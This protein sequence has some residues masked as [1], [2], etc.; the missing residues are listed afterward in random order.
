MSEKLKNDIL[1]IKEIGEKIAELS[2][3]NIINP[4][5]IRTLMKVLEYGDVNNS[6]SKYLKLKKLVYLTEKL[7]NE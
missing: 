5:Y 2:N 4:N 1:Q 6:K 7:A 3:F